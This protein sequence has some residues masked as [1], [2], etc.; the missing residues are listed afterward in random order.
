MKKSKVKMI[1][2]KHSPKIVIE[3]WDPGGLRAKNLRKSATSNFWKK[4]KSKLFNIK[5]SKQRKQAKILKQNPKSK[6]SPQIKVNSVLKKIQ[7]IL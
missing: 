2:K 7:V 4:I 3:K 5:C 1:K 6:F